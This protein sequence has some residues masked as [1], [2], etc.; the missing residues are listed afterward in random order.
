MTTDDRFLDTLETWLQAEAG[1]GR[2]VY[3][4]E[5][6]ARTARARQDP[7]WASLDRWI[8]V[9]RRITVSLAG[10]P[11]S[12]KLLVVAALV[13]SLALAGLR[14]RA[15]PRCRRR[16]ASP[17]TAR[18]SWPAWRP[19]SSP[20]PTVRIPIRCSPSTGSRPVVLARW[21]EARVSVGR[22]RHGPADRAGLRPRDREVTDVSPRREIEVGTD[23]IAWAPDSRRLVTGLAFE[24]KGGL[25][26][27]AA[28]GSESAIVAPG[29]TTERANAFAPA[30]TPHGEW[31]AFL[32]ERPGTGDA[33]LFVVR[34]DGR[35][36]HLVATARRYPEVGAPSWSPE[37]GWQRLLYVRP[38]GGIGVVDLADP[39]PVLLAVTAN[40]EPHW[41]TWSPDGTSIAWFDGGLLVGR[42]DDLLA[43]GSPRRLSTLHG[44]CRDNRDLT[45]TTPCG[46]PVWS[47]DGRSIVGPDVLGASMVAISV[48]GSQPPIHIPLTNASDLTAVG[49]VAWQRRAP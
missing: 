7:A 16:S 28:D 23:V 47:P 42:L 21:D 38:D 31:I 20:T 9:R 32:G 33:G 44:S 12:V 1:D 37:S 26:R 14:S 4:E 48:D 8:P 17:R 24:A 18:S 46:E 34:P 43:G 22:S 35:D 27:F 6:L 49:A 5:L 29:S 2:P 36:E 41:P 15:A 10:V 39:E 45:G 30:W 40:A 11:R 19:S 13:L 3:T 25:R